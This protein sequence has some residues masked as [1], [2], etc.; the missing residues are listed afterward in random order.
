MSLS[1]S[2]E[3][4][5]VCDAY[6]PHRRGSKAEVM[7]AWKQAKD[8]PTLNVLLAAIGRYK[9][10][11]DWVDGV[12]LTLPH[13]LNQE[14]WKHEPPPA[15][16]TMY[17][18]NLIEGHRCMQKAHKINLQDWRTNTALASMCKPCWESW[19]KTAPNQGRCV[20]T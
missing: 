9:Q 13:W 7:K 6:P 14:G 1:E 8:R 4:E 19:R 16:P 17:C 2:T 18:Q 11:K 12:I 5:A 3:L 10:S 15:D 20:S